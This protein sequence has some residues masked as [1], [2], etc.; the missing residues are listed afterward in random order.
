MSIFHKGKPI[1]TT[2]TT[3]FAIS[4][5]VQQTNAGIKDLEDKRVASIENVETTKINSLNEIEERKENC[6]SEIENTR[7]SVVADVTAEGTVQVNLCKDQ[8]NLA[9]DEVALATAQAELATQ[10]AEE[11]VGVAIGAYL[12]I[13]SNQTYTPPGYLLRDGAEYSASQ[14]QDLWDKWLTTSLY[15]IRGYMEIYSSEISKGFNA[16]LIFKTGTDITLEQALISY[17]GYNLAYIS[18]GVIQGYSPNEGSVEFGDVTANTEI[19]VYLSCNSELITLT[20][21]NI[22]VTYEFQDGEKLR[23]NANYNRGL[24]LLSSSLINGSAL[25][26]HGKYNSVMSYVGSS[27][28]LE[29]IGTTHVGSLI[30]AESYADYQQQIDTYGYC[31]KFGVGQR[32]N[33]TSSNAG[34]TVSGEYTGDEDKVFTATDETVINPILTVG[35]L[36]LN[37]NGIISNFAYNTSNIIKWNI[38]P[39]SEFIIKINT[40]SDINTTQGIFGSDVSV[41]IKGG[42]LGYNSQ[43]SEGSF[44]PVVTVSTGQDI[45]IKYVKKSSIDGV[46]Y[47]SFTGEP[48]SYLSINQSTNSLFSSLA[49][50]YGYVAGSYYPF[51]GSVDLN[52][53]SYVDIEGRTIMLSSLNWAPSLSLYGLTVT[54]IPNVGDT[55]AV[56]LE[57]TIKAP[58]ANP[59]NRVLIEK[60]EP[61]E[62]DP[63]WYNLYNDGWC[64]QGGLATGGT[65]TRG[66]TVYLFIPYMD[67][68]YTLTATANPATN[69]FANTTVIWVKVSKS[70][71]SSFITQTG[72]NSGTASETKLSWEAKGYTNNIVEN[73]TRPYVVVANGELNES[74]MNW[75]QWATSLEG[76][77]DKGDMIPCATIIE[78]YESGTEGYIVYS[79]NYCEQWGKVGRTAVSQAI[80][81][82]KPYRDVNYGIVLQAYHTALSTDG[83][84]P[85]VYNADTAPDGFT[86]NLYTGYAGAYWRTYGFVQG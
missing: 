77:V 69:P 65:T 39:S 57:N 3:P 30:K 48:S 79:N 68:N 56:A 71:N 17:D 34:L 84:P 73:T 61:T 52:N 59:N 55:I 72:Y 43:A 46:A 14:F 49:I 78:W 63:T 51:L 82:F 38:T 28:V 47:Y 2:G 80:T 26:S 31:D 16:K 62:S 35:S 50:G 10:K 15:A 64:E 53:S 12:D 8:V 11:A 27:T 36:C 75:S 45:W 37:N 83:R 4:D 21:N 40:G 6:I 9:K 29:E 67:T 66:N 54:G 20:I 5:I 60:K 19:L 24:S 7:A 81:L 22:S 70:S 13:A 44:T 85:L 58:L 1:A 42:R 33:I 41:C 86:I 32:A 23:P 76:K 25:Y 74:D 18:N